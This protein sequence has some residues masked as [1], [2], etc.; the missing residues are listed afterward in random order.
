MERDRPGG[1]DGAVAG[2]GG[3]GWLAAF[4]LDRGRARDY[5]SRP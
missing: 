3:G 5:R 4:L 1:G 2:G